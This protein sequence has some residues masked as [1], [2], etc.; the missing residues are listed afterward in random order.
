MPKEQE[1]PPRGIHIT[2]IKI[3]DFSAAAETGRPI[4]ERKAATQ[5]RAAQQNRGVHLETI[6][7]RYNDSRKKRGTEIN[8]SALEAMTRGDQKQ[9]MLDGLV[10]IHD[11]LLPGANPDRATD[12]DLREL[13]VIGEALPSYLILRAQNPVDRMAVPDEVGNIYKATIGLRTLANSRIHNNMRSTIDSPSEV[14]VYAN[15]LDLLRDKEDKDFACAAPPDLIT[16]AA[17]ALVFGN[18]GDSSR[19]VLATLISEDERPYLFGY[20]ELL[21]QYNDHILALQMGEAPAGQVY[22][23]ISQIQFE[24]NEVLGRDPETAHP[25]SAA[26]LME[27]KANS[28]TPQPDSPLKKALEETRAE[29][30]LAVP[31]QR[32]ETLEFRPLERRGGK[33]RRG[34]GGR[35]KTKENRGQEQTDRNTSQS[36]QDSGAFSL[37]VV[38]EPE[39]SPD[40]TVNF[41]GTNGVETQVFPNPETERT[42]D[43]R[44]DDRE[45]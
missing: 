37:P 13:A 11:A 1:Q 4:H 10:W 9:R 23:A 14:Y 6:P 24:M 29:Q 7:S 3:V 30:G 25:F 41:I 19:S 26:D 22:T 44:P 34:K 43:D 39:A 31:G 42:Q 5:F 33:N 40:T 20:S 36:D 28:Y 16:K 35:K 18:G 27:L 2:D 32:V 21:A 12:D 8:I 45:R 17:D 38:E 15:A